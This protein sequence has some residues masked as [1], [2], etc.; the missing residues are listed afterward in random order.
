VT[1]TSLARLRVFDKPNASIVQNSV[2]PNHEAEEVDDAA[3]GPAMFDGPTLVEAGVSA[4][5]SASGE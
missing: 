5:R 3:T 2:L 1:D 4:S